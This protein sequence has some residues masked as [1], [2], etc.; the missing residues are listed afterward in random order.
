MKTKII[1]EIASCHNGDLEMAKALIRSA[2]ENGADIVKFQDWRSS[3]VLENDPDKQR[4]ELYQFPD[5]WYPILIDYCR[6]CGVEF[7]TT[8]FNVDRVE[9]LAKLGLKKIKLASISLTNTEL[10]MMA[11]LF[12]EEVILS[13][14][15]QSREEIENAI[16]ILTTNAQK[17][18][19]LHCV[20]N[21]P[22]RPEDANLERINEIRKLLPEYASV[23]YS[24]HSLDLDVA[25]TALC[26]DIEYIE[27]HFSLSRDLPQIK[28]Q[29]YKDGL[30]VTTHEI[31]INPEELLELSKWRDKVYVIYGD[32]K[33]IINDIEKKI[34]ERYN[35]R[36]GN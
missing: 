9:F 19:I 12:F 33:F 1:V 4:Y 31:S 2:S 30:M 26:M 25:K 15:M 36:Y 17:F 8:C 11:G 14:G 6:E 18:A 28:H 34:K 16:D 22:T 27:K 3:N 32:G 35:K 20:A 21:Y 13:T 24:D 5:E 7:L 23:G 10:L 29:M